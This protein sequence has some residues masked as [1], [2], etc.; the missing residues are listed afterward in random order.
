MK[1]RIHKQTWVILLAGLILPALLHLA[2][3]P[4][5]TNETIRAILLEDADVFQEQ[6]AELEKVAQAYVQQ[7][8]ALDELQNQ[9]AATR[10]AY[11]RLEYLMEYY[12]P[13]AVKGGINGAPLY[14]LDPYMPRPVIHEPNGLQSLDE[15]VFSEEAPEER[16]HIASLCEELKG[17]Y[18][19]I[20][21]DFKGHP[22]LDREVF[23]ASRLQLVR[24]FTLGVTGFDTPGSLNGLAESRRSLQSLQ[25]IM[26]IYIRQL[27]DEGKELGVE[28]DRLFSGAIG[29]LER[30]ND[31]NSFDRLYFLKAFI[32]PLFG[33]LLDLH[34]ALHLETVYETTNLEQS[35]NYNS[36]SIFDEDFLNPYYYTKVVR[37]PNDEKR[38][39]LGQRLFY[40][41]RLSGNQT[42]SCAS[43]HHPDKAFT[44]GMAKSAGNKQGEFVDRN[45]PSLINA[46]FSMRFFWDMRAFRFEDQMEHVIISHKEFNTS[47]EAIF[48]KL[49][50]DE[51]YQR[52]FAEAYPEVKDYPAINRSTLSDALSRY[53]MSLVAFNSPFDQYVRNERKEIDP[54]VKDGF[55]LFMGKAACGTC[56]FAPTFSGLAPPLYQ[57]SESEVLGVLEMPG[58]AEPRM[59]SDPGRK[60]NRN[61]MEGVWFYHNS[62]KTVTVRNV[63]L[64]GPYFHNGAYGNLQEVV[65]F[66]D[67]GGA[68]GLGLDVPHQTLAGDSLHLSD[69]EKEALIEFMSS[70]E[71]TSTFSPYLH[72]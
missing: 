15:L 8:V 9:L 68:A 27:Q 20:Q 45:A 66:Y 30:E 41:T 5:S 51:E 70:L 67:H 50:A 65:D 39:L 34:R 16:E 58:T 69:Y 25:E 6:V 47:Y 43:C 2:F 32:D 59:D 11:K 21:R 60:A 35:W 61:P 18:A 38:K 10:L 64:S 31:F 44:D 33:G 7:E 55:N 28:V 14:H 26:A 49:R 29:Y 13:T 62:F 40:E 19:N 72:P 24:L 1:Y 46:V 56:H 52:L 54:R 71:H 12:Y 63:S 57:D 53:L 36:R 23:E 3:R 42:R 17:A 37:S 22:M 48:R 4:V